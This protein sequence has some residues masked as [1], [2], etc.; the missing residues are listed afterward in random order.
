MIQKIMPKGIKVISFDLDD[1]LWSGPQVIRHAEAVMQNWMAEHTPRVLSQF[2]GEQFLEKK[3]QFIKQNPQL[4]NKISLS[5]QV[6]LQQL[7]SELGYKNAETLSQDCFHAFYHA[8][9]NVTLFDDVLS[10]LDALKQNY[11]LISI[12]NGNAD[13]QL[14]PLANA[15]ELSLVAEHFERPKPHDDIF[16]HALEQLK[17][18]PH[19]VLHVGDHPVHDVQGAHEIGMKTCWLNDGSRQWTLPFDA[20]LT[21][22]HVRELLRV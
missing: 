22:S 9:Q 13:V 19:E 3:I 17:C 21:I 5:R 11:R 2:N 15:F 14:T 8:R 16:L 7:F 10:T 20:H 4:K 12:T 6:F 18:E 1:T